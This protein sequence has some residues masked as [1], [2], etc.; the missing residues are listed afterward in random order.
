LI[1]VVQLTEQLGLLAQHRF[2]PLQ[3]HLAGRRQANLRTQAI[4]QGRAQALLQLCHLL[5]DRGLADVQ[6]FAGLGKTAPV[7]HFNKT[8]QLFEFHSHDSSLE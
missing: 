6:G 5:A 2:C 4:Q 7:D 8:A 1:Q 3:H